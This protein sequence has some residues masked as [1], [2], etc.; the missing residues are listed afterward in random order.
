MECDDAKALMHARK[1]S[2]AQLYSSNKHVPSSSSTTLSFG[3][4]IPRRPVSSAT[5]AHPRPATMIAIELPMNTSS[6]PPHSQLQ[7]DFGH[8]GTASC[9]S[10]IV[11]PQSPFA[12]SHT[13]IYRFVTGWQ[14]PPPRTYSTQ[15]F[16]NQVEHPKPLYI[17]LDHIQLVRCINSNNAGLTHKMSADAA[18]GDCLQTRGKFAARK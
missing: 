1:P 8:P 2:I 3:P 9:V 7:P 11:H 5:P 6:T 12:S 15:A 10:Y 18:A 14:L 4:A 13:G 16:P 17:E